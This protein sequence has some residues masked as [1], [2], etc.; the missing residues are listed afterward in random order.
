MQA[1]SLSEPGST[2]QKKLACVRQIPRQLL[3]WVCFAAG[4]NAKCA[5]GRRWARSDWLVALLVAC[6]RTASSCVVDSQWKATVPPSAR[7]DGGVLSFFASIAVLPAA[8]K[9][10]S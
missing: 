10:G 9:K 2:E 3:D 8:K 5:K 1:L 7:G 4:E 6:Q